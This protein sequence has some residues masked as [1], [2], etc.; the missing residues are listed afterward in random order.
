MMA[1]KSQIVETS[2]GDFSKFNIEEL[3]LNE[4]FCFKYNFNR[5]SN[6]ET[7]RKPRLDGFHLKPMITK[8]LI[9][10]DPQTG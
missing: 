4:V 5:A 6:S 10:K 8:S 7:Q 9:P 1:L 3:L 2:D